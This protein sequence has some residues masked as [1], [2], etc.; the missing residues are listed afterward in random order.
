M[1]ATP[2]GANGAKLPEEKPVKATAQKNSSTTT[3]MSTK[4]TLAVALSEVPRSSSQVAS[5][6]MRTAARLTTPPSWPGERVIA[7]GSVQP[8]RLCRNALRY[9]PQP[10]A[11]AATETAYSSIRHQP[12]TQAISSPS[13]AYA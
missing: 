12:H 2:I 5:S 10:T 7:S 4:T 6:T 11:T 3:L 8:T 9:S 13:V 1:P